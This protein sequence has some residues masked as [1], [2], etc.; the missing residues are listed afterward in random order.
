MPQLIDRQD[1]RKLWEDAIAEDGTHNDITSLVS[2]TS[3]QAIAAQVVAREPGIFAGSVIFNV[4]KEAYPTE[5][6]VECCVADGDRLQAGT[7]IAQITGS[8]RVL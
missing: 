5:L 4:V 2:A 8:A 7:M 3:K 6:T 1:L